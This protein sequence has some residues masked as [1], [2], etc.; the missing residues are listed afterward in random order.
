MRYFL[1][2]VFLL[3]NCD[4]ESKPTRGGGGLDGEVA[5]VAYVH[6]GLPKGVSDIASI[7]VEVRGNVTHYKYAFMTDASISCEDAEYGDFLPISA[8]LQL[9]LGENGDKVICLIGKDSEGNEQ[10]EPERYQWIKGSAPVEVSEDKRLPAA[11]VD[12]GMEAAYA[13]SALELDILGEY[14]ATKYQYVFMEEGNF[15]CNGL[16]DDNYGEEK[17]IGDKLTLNIETERAYTLCLRGRNADDIQAEISVYS[18]EKVSASTELAGNLHVNRTGIIFFASTS[19]YIRTLKLENKSTGDLAW[20]IAAAEE[21]DWLQVK[22]TGSEYTEIT[23]GDVIS[24][25][26]LAGGTTTISL[27]LA[28]VY[29]TD[30]GKPHERVSELEITNVSEGKSIKVETKLYVPEVKLS[31]SETISE[32]NEPIHLS[33]NNAEE[34]LY[35][36]NTG[37]GGHGR[38]AYQTVP[39]FIGKKNNEGE[40]VYYKPYSEQTKTEYKDFRSI[41][42]IE[43][44]KD[45][46][47]RRFLKFSVNKD[48]LAQKPSDYFRDVFFVIVSNTDSKDQLSSCTGFEGGKE[49]DTGLRVFTSWVSTSVCHIF[50]VHLQKLESG[51]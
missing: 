37:A 22:K 16:S 41:V 42:S 10:S 2:I 31:R 33:N 25:I 44:Q 48:K 12:G 5:H 1:P 49:Y 28:D 3:V 40:M 13:E 46:D 23:A 17:N 21:I 27:R 39:I 43:A 47:H 4:E 35:L 14:G 45:E 7:D 32:S 29:K 15:D 36:L 9:D 51:E 8:R 6:P 50:N 38:V 11:V 20:K 30:Y 34:K 24:G 18:F 19:K 26:L